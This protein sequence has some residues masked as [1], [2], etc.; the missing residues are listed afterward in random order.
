MFRKLIIVAATVGLL[1]GCTATGG[2]KQTGGAVL[3]GLAGGLAG[4]QIGGGEGRLWATG[5]GVLLGALIGSE[6]GA[7]LDRADQ[8]A[9]ERNTRVAWEPSTPIGRPIVWDNP[10]NGN[11]VVVTPTREGS[12][13]YG[14]YCREYQ[15]TITVGG[16]TEEAYGTACQQPDGSW[17]I[18]S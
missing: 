17:K 7:S 10:N 6:I 18:V 2:Q 3:G 4:S 11:R 14:S 1:A 9:L 8:A 13:N 5:A 12:T 15:Q 16:R